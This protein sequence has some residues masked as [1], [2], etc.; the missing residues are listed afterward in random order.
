MKFKLQPYAHQLKILEACKIH[1]DYALLWEMGTGK[2]GAI[3]NVLRYQYG[4]RNRIL[5]TLIL[6]P[7]AVVKNWKRSML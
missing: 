6:G 5:K 3:I 4:K 2:T 7:L 1:D